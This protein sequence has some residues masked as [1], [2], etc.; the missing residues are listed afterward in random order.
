LLAWLKVLLRVDSLTVA[1]GE[2]SVLLRKREIATEE[3]QGC[4]PASFVK[5]DK[6]QRVDKGVDECHMQRHLMSK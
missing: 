4:F 3:V 5:D 2:K 1:G 6:Q